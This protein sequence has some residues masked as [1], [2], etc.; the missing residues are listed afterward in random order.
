LGLVSLLVMKLNPKE[1]FDIVGRGKVFTFDLVENGLPSLRKDIYDM[2]R[3]SKVEI[4]NKLWE[5]RGIE[6]MG[7]SE[8]CGH[9]M[10]GLLVKVL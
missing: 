3:G 9:R 10:M 1:E 4:N 6:L 8:D 7:L 2:F 5:V